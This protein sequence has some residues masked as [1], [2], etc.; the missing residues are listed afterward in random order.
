MQFPDSTFA[1]LRLGADGADDAPAGPRL[2]LIAIVLTVSAI[3]V[4]WLLAGG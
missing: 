2:L 1:A 3:S 4:G